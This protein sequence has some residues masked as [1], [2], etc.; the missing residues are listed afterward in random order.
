MEIKKW[1]RKDEYYSSL[2]PTLGVYRVYKKGKLV[3]GISIG[4]IKW[5]ITINF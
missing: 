2:L 1:P 4:W 5:G 3:K